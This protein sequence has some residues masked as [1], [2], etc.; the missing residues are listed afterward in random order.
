[1]LDVTRSHVARCNSINAKILVR[2]A[3]LGSFCS[4]HRRSSVRSNL[5]SI[6]KLDPETRIDGLLGVVCSVCW[7]GTVS[8]AYGHTLTRLS[9]TAES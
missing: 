9:R 3:H 6:T 7:L 2:Q 4:S 5:L 8:T 1:M